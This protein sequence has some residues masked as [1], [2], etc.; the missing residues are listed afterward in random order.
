MC[1]I[2][3]YQGPPIP[4]ENIIVR[5]EHSLLKQSQNATEAKL[6]VNGDGFGISWYG[7]D[8]EPG[9]YRDI[10]P[11]WS[12]GNLPS[13]CRMIRSPLFIGHVR[14]STTG[15]TMRV[16]CHPFTNGPVSFCHNGQ[17]PGFDGM[18]RR[19]EAALPDE[20]YKAKRG[21]TD[22]ELIFLTLLSNGLVQDPSTALSRTIAALGEP[23]EP[24]KL[25]LVWSDGR[26][27]FGYRYASKGPAPT[28]YVSGPLRHGGRA[29][30]SEPLDS[31][32]TD[33]TMVPERQVCTLAEHVSAA[34]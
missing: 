27:L 28:L 18:R 30:A 24:I 13:L 17:V 1:R 8:P 26:D 5:P 32:T 11:A 25:T 34:A 3:A 22:S 33:W 20:L 16:N 21:T 19:I 31:L 2:A 10:L 15:E 23:H 12:D 14:A 6:S 7:T 9:L 4:L 29:F